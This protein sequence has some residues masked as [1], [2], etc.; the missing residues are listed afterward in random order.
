MKML[1][2]LTTIV[3]ALLFFG[4]EKPPEDERFYFISGSTSDEIDIFVNG[5]PTNAG[6]ALTLFLVDGQNSIELRGDHRA[7]GY[8][9]Q[10]F[11]GKSIFDADS[12]KVVEKQREASEEPEDELISF[13]AEVDDKWA[14][15]EAE[16]LGAMSTEDQ[17]AIYSIYDSICNEMK[18]DG[19]DPKDLLSRGDVI[20][21]RKSNEHGS[22][23]KQQLE[24][25]GAKIPPRSEL[26]FQNA[27]HDELRLISG[28]QIAMLTCNQDKLVYL[29]PPE[30]DKPSESGEIKWTFYYGFSEMFFAKFNGSWKLMLPNL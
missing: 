12:Q 8:H 16:S 19:F 18:G 11:R 24:E 26:V 10:V 9:L 15:Q 30:D 4:C 1:L 5:N 27:A 6:N 22:K 29:G 20:L 14:W 2:R 7:G 28:K 13:E 3:F 21:W 23:L 17:K 25:I